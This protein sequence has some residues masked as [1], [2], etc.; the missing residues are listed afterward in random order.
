M[1]NYLLKLENGLFALQHIVYII[2]DISAYTD[3][4]G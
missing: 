4:V 3:S 2:M 1:E